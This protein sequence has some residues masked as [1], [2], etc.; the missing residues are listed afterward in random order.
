MA[1][2]DHASAFY[3]YIGV[4]DFVAVAASGKNWWKCHRVIQ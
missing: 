2:F 3:R 4:D 1:D